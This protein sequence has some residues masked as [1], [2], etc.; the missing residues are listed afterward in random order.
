MIKLLEMMKMN[1]SNA[2]SNF[3][4]NAKDLTNVI[5]AQLDLF[6]K[7]LKEKIHANALIIQ[8]N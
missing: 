5:N 2:I 6:P 3:V 4:K 7:T 1:R 8:D